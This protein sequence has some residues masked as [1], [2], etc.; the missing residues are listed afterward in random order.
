MSIPDFG[1]DS[2]DSG[3]EPGALRL[4]E[5]I[6]SGLCVGSYDGSEPLE[7]RWAKV[8]SGPDARMALVM[9]EGL[10]GSP[11]I[12]SPSSGNRPMPKSISFSWVRDWLSCRLIPKRLFILRYFSSSS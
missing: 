1:M 2:N 8:D 9:E 10:R 12:D 4:P 11:S 6:F 5:F 7:T 3:G